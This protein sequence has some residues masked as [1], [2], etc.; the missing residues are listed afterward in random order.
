MWEAA[1]RFLLP[2]APTLDVDP[3]LNRDLRPSVSRLTPGEVADRE[4]GCLQELGKEPS[5]Y[6]LIYVT[7]EFQLYGKLKLKVRRGN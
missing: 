2:P 3:F 6:F 5:N 7:W 1:A 4:N